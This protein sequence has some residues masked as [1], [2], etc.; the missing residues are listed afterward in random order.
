[1]QTTQ[2]RIAIIGTGGIGA[3]Y[4]AKLIES[5]QEV[6]LV[7][8]ERH[9]EA[10]RGGGLVLATDAGEQTL[11]PASITTDA[12]EIG[13]VDIVLVTVKLYQL[14]EATA[15][16]DSL[17]GPDT[18]VVTTQN[19]ISAPRLL[20]ERLGPERVVPG[21][22]FI[23]AYL[24]GPGRVRHRGGRAGLTLSD[25]TLAGSSSA[26]C[27]PMIEALAS[28]GVDA[29]FTASIDLELW[30]KFALITTFGG[31]CG[32]AD[33]TIGTVRSFEPTRSLLRQALDEARSV[34][35]AVGVDLSADDTDAI[36]GRL[37]NAAPEATTSMQRDIAEGKPSE[38]DYLNGE[39]VRLAEQHS[40]DIPCQRTA[41]AI[42]SL[43]ERANR[44]S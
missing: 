3:Y 21:I 44:H 31:V 32:M 16:I 38:L 2:P 28:V 39:L 30:R 20:A 40:V 23:V 17:L 41:L 36:L 25:R 22:A 12:A 34:A 4:G 42:L 13:P 10:V 6:H 43:R 35:R 33:S 9:V 19:G 7:S 24:E 8:T 15:G 14:Q 11:H 1:M 18:L 26:R 5:G 27:A 37:D 29:A